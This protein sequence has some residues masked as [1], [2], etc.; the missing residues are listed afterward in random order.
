MNTP[1]E[2]FFAQF[3]NLGF[4][5]RGSATALNNFERLQEV[6][7]WG[8]DSED[9]REA[10]YDFNNAL[11]R[12]FNVTIGTETD[13]PSWQNL[14][15][16]IDITP[17]PDTIQECRRVRVYFHVSKRGLGRSKLMCCFDFQ[18]VRDSH[19]NIVDL[20]ESARTGNPVRKFRTV[21]ELSVYTISTR[22]IFPKGSAYAGGLLKELLRE[23]FKHG[24]PRQN[25]GAR[26]RRRR[27]ARRRAAAAAQPSAS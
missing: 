21:E 15:R 1:L 11:T 20:L 8:D 4:E 25:G 22:R 24:N 26:R 13:L 23:I 17:V 19:V 9:L 10:L 27:R 18:R 16:L 5:Y 2:V 3:A 12:Q 14:C 6:S 7:R